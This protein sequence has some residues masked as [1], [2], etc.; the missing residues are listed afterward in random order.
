MVDFLNQEI[1]L[2]YLNIRSP[3]WIMFFS[4]KF[5]DNYEEVK[6]FRLFVCLS[7]VSSASLTVL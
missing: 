6:S 5:R 1:F 2:V 4:P 7:A 3:P